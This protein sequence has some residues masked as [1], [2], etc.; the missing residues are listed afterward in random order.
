MGSEMCIRDSNE[1]GLPVI[2]AVDASTE[3]E[4]HGTAAGTGPAF[5]ASGNLVRGF[6]VHVSVVDPL[7]TPLVAQ[8]VDIETARY[9]G[10]ISGVTGTGF[11]YTRKFALATDDY[12]VSLD[13]ISANTRNGT[14]SA[15]AITGFKYWDFAF[16]AQVTAG[17]NVSA[18]QTVN[19]LFTAATT[20]AVNF[21]GTIG[22]VVPWGVSFATWGDPANAMGWSAPWVVLEPV[23]LPLGV[24]TGTA[25]LSASN[26]FTMTVPNAATLSPTIDVDTASGSATLVYRVDRSNGVVTVSPEDITTSAG[27][28]ALNNGL[29]V[30]AP[31]KVYGVPQSDGSLRAYVLLYY[32]GAAPSL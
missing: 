13:F 1:A 30:N 15:G 29:A 2:V 3:F 6:K 31:V 26:T 11:D 21:G 24:V 12:N 5:L 8:T 22:P 9:E 10:S 18:G 4:F 7:A 14:D 20:N 32:T 28:T 25:G 16:P 19:G 27:L 17:N 23:P